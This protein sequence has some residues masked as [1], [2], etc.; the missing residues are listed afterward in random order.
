MRQ[1]KAW[2]TA[3]VVL[4][5]SC[6]DSST[7]AAPDD[8]GPQPDF[9]CS[10]PLSQIFSGGV[11]RDQIPALVRPNLG[12]PGQTPAGLL[13]SDRVIGVV[14]NGAARAYPLPVMWYHEIVNDTLGGQPVLVS[15]CPLTGTGIAFDPRV[16][17]QTREFGVSGVL[18]RSNL[19]M[20]DRESESLWTQMLLGSQC[21]V[22]RGKGLDRINAL[23]TTLEHWKRLHPNTTVVTTN[24]G[25]DRDYRGYPYGD[26][27]D[28]TNEQVPF[29]AEG[30]RWNP[31]LPPKEVVLGVIDG[32]SQG[33]ECRPFTDCDAIVYSLKGLAEQGPAVTVNDSVGKRALLITYQ[34]AFGT[35]NAFDRTVNGEPLTFEVVTANPLT[36][37]DRE[38]GTIWN[39]MGTAFEGQ[40][41]GAQLEPITDA[42]V[43][44]WFAWSLFF[45]S[46][47]LYQ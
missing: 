41:A 28:L 21:G 26:Y 1:N 2:L 40:L 5:A 17:G 30:V 9:T 34:D 29:L 23:E 4:A 7:P 8:G 35:A 18:Y 44:F 12:S 10:I 46:L 13:D 20:F 32:W 36:M 25:F 14:V 11:G 24:T 6:G 38:T 47:R 22:E 42:Y 45:K 16:D 43:G 37:R 15:Y 33:V 27:R 31:L 39:E 19:M 3:A